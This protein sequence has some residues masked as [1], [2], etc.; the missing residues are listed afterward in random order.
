[1]FKEDPFLRLPSSRDECEKEIEG[2]NEFN[3]ARYPGVELYVR[4]KTIV[5]KTLSLFAFTPVRY[6][7][8]DEDQPLR[9][10]P[11]TMYPHEVPTVVC[12]PRSPLFYY[13]IVF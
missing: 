12:V 8:H 10:S 13:F 2:D 7:S 1:M 9:P 5:T 6:D 3:L 11:S 4:L